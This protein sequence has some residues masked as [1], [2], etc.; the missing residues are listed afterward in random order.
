MR[1]NSNMPIPIQKPGCAWIE[2][3]RSCKK[4]EK[5]VISS[6]CQQQ[7]KTIMLASLSTVTSNS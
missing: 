1:A 4:A 3:R 5:L 2:V 7:K 6:S